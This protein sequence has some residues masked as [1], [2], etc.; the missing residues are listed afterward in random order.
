MSATVR[1]S[2]ALQFTWPFQRKMSNNY[3]S[4]VKITYLKIEELSAYWKIVC[5][6]KFSLEIE[7][8]SLDCRTICRFRNFLNIK[9]LSAD[10]GISCRS[11]NYLHIEKVWNFQIKKYL[12][13]EEIFADQIIICESKKCLAY[14]LKNYL[15]FDL[16]VEQVFILQIKEFSTGQRTICISFKYLQIDWLSA[17]WKTSSAVWTK[18][19]A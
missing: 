4:S 9:K 14:R 1:K 11:K 10:Q 6:S 7:D 3:F 13:I 15:H 17:D 19:A 8:I 16:K 12:L 18:S 5:F 2:D